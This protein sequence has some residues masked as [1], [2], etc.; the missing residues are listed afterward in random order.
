MPGRASLSLALLLIASGGASLAHAEVDLQ[1]GN[2][3]SIAP[4]QNLYSVD[5]QA[6]WTA[7]D[8]DA[9]ELEFSSVDMLY[10]FSG[11]ELVSVTTLLPE[12]QAID[13]S[14]GS[15]TGVIGMFSLGAPIDLPSEPLGLFTLEVAI[16][17]DETTSVAPSITLGAPF[18]YDD[19][20][21]IIAFSNDD[22]SL[23]IPAPATLALL[24]GGL[25][26]FRRRR[27]G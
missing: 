1:F 13:M 11:V 3:T 21:D 10:T 8:L 18:F 24:A 23:T 16:T 12:W 20:F 15:G 14:V 2:L 6:T 25:G 22:Y 27:T 26:G 19:G 5:V 9:L 7:G 4:E 17:A